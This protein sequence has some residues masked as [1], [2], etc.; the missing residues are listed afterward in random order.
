MK[1]KQIIK[2]KRVELAII[3]WIIIVLGYWV[4]WWSFLPISILAGMLLLG[5][6]TG[7]PVLIAVVNQNRHLQLIMAISIF[8]LLVI[9]LLTSIAASQRN[10]RW[11]LGN[12]VLTYERAV[13]FNQRQLESRIENRSFRRDSAQSWRDGGYIDLTVMTRPN[14]RFTREQLDELGRIANGFEMLSDDV[15]GHFWEGAIWVRYALDHYWLRTYPTENEPL[16]MTRHAG[17]DTIYDVEENIAVV[18][19]RFPWPFSREVLRLP[20]IDQ[21]GEFHGENFELAL[22]LQQLMLYEYFETP[23]GDRTF[24][25]TKELL[26]EHQ[27]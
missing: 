7:V 5:L 19:V 12:T 23:R 18:E 1:I 22:Q 2:E 13:L 26:Y 27:R 4:L 9:L 24:E 11:G 17:L 25:R 6:L 10:F 15:R 14:Y 21:Y 8:F 20:L 16:T 3:I